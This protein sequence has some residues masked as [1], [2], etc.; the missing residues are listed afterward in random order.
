M[1]RLLYSGLRL[2]GA[3]CAGLLALIW[4]VT[5]VAAATQQESLPSVTFAKDIAPVLFERCG[6]CHHPDG[7]AP[8][9]L[10]TY[11]AAKSRARLIAA[12]TKDR[13][14]P[15]WKSEPGYGDFIGHRHL[16]EAEI[17]RI[18]RWAE[19]GA[20]EGDPRDLPPAPG[21]PAGWRLGTP[22]L[23]VSLPEPYMVRAEGPDFS[24]TFVLS[25]PVDRTRY[26]KGFEFRPGNS[27]VVH[28]ANIRIDRTPGSRRLDEE[29][30][31]PGYYGL[32]LPSAVYPDGHFLGWTPGQ[33][34]PLL[35]KD[36][37][38]VLTPGTDLVV[39]IH[40]V[41][42]GKTETVRP[43][44][45]LYLGDDPP[46]RTP[47]M[48]R[49]GRQDIQIPAG[50][51]DYVSTDSFVLPVDVTAEAVQPHA[52]YRAREVRGTATLP[53]GTTMPLIYIKDWDYRW[54]HVYRYV[55]PLVLPKG[56]TLS[57]RYVFDNSA[58]NPRNPHQPP[59]PVHWGQQSTDEMGD[60]WVQMLTRNEKDLQ[61]LNDT[62]RVKHVTEEIVGY[63]M[64]IRS[65]PFKISLHND[66]ALMY[67]EMNQPDK[68]AAHFETVV[69]IQ[70]NA[71]AAHY[72]LGRALSSMGNVADA[73]AQYREALRLQ[74]DYA[75]ARN[76]LGQGLLALGN[77]DEAERQFL[78]AE[79]LDPGNAAVQSNLGAM[80]RARGDIPEAINRF[81]QAVRLRPDWVQAVGNLAWLLATSPSAALRDGNRAVNLAEH[82]AD[83]TN[84]QSA[85]I[86]DILA[87]AQAAAG[88]FDLAE[89]T[90]EAALALQPDDRLATA[91]RQRF[92]LY[93]QRRPYILP[94][95]TP[96]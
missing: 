32:L 30:P 96:W 21:W 34:A 25:L 60:L 67:A 77:R 37:A 87:A 5:S 79:R 9:S 28:H 8:F 31:S 76:N 92:A 68:A 89:A 18:R 82:A 69:R 94:P 7:A 95:A 71:A 91:I 46:A 64:M 6:S 70:P 47:A 12:V 26:V 56:T 74:P 62:L 41:P 66:V 90:C 23:V 24:R 33:Y 15:P 35:P 29:D 38:W 53:D 45:G 86:L 57:M 84:R 50:Q 40:F 49:L 39:E 83:L 14:M 19:S 51:K 48:L 81:R 54:Q 78:E 93:L 55:T 65:E 52:H 44:V 73:I 61:L 43:V 22:D 59:H 63:E 58:E 13:L 85:G 4:G 10:L 3:I 11:A 20:P 88:R 75:L 2:Q 27:G 16:S 72:N 36:L 1:H 42:S 80:A 17:D